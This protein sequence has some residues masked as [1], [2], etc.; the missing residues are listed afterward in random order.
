MFY[1]K[2]KLIE[3]YNL[4]LN[5]K[6]SWYKIGEGPQN[7]RKKYNF[8]TILKNNK[9]KNQITVHPAFLIEWVL[10]SELRECLT[11]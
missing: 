11:G 8:V 1:M 7:P 10:C 2:Q 6:F 3:N 5:S 4:K 9:I